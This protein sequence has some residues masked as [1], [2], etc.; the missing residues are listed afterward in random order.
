MCKGSHPSQVL[1]K[2]SCNVTENEVMTFIKNITCGL[3]ELHGLGYCHGDLHDRNIM[4]RQIGENSVLPEVQYVIIDFSEA[5]PIESP[6]EGLQ[7][8]TDCIS[9]HLRTFSDCLYQKDS[10]T[11]NEEKLLFTISHI[12][13]M[14]NGF[15]PESMR[16]TS[17][18]FIL[19]S[20]MD[21]YSIRRQH[22]ES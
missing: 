7:K 22:L 3:E 5:N 11:R 14:L 20:F 15:T 2:E 12:P 19:D 18:K 10:L 9:V 6:S 4:R 1:E 16:I 8:D 21:G 17:P 13:G